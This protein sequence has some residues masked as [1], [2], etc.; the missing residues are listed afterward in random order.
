MNSSAKPLI[1]SPELLTCKRDSFPYLP[2]GTGLRW[3]E[4]IPD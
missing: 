3:S 1:P 4:K 2:I